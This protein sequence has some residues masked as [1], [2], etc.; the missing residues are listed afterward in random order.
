VRDPRGPRAG[1]PGRVDRPP[2][3]PSGTRRTLSAAR[4]RAQGCAG[5]RESEV[6]APAGD[7]RR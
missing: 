5:P 4:S 3:A 1:T 2:R 7:R 6:R